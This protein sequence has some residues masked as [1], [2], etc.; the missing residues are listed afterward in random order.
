MIQLSD[1]IRLF[2]KCILQHNF[3]VLLI[4][5]YSLS[6][7]L[8]FIYNPI[9]YK[10]LKTGK[11]YYK[12]DTAYSLSFKLDKLSITFLVY[13]YKPLSIS[14]SYS[15]SDLYSVSGFDDLFIETS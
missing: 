10:P 3:V 14:I 9:E 11:H 6:I 8:Q 1:F 2:D 5:Q 4:F 13:S 15:V 7:L 12:Y